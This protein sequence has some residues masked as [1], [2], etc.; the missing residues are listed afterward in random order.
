MSR[1]GDPVACREHFELAVTYRVDDRITYLRNLHLPGVTTVFSF[2][3]QLSVN[4][5]INFLYAVC[6]VTE[7]IRLPGGNVVIT[8]FLVPIAYVIKLY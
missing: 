8:G 2:G 3:S 6:D 5:N 4:A 7:C 1:S